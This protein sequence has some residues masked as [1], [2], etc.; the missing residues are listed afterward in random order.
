VSS[1]AQAAAHLRK[2]RE[3]LEAAQQSLESER[4]DVAVSTAVT[5]GINSSDAALLALT[6]RSPKSGDHSDAVE[7]LTAA[8]AAARPMATVLGRLLVHKNAAQ[9]QSAPMSASKARSAV[10]WAERLYTAAQE[11]VA[12]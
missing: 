2:A 8:G 6:G 5:S 1:R 3:F 12:G 9:Y 4:Y 10:S 7:R 11:V